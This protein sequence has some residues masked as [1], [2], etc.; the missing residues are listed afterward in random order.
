[1]DVVQPLIALIDEEGRRRQVSA[2][3]AYRLTE[4]Q[5]RA[6]LDLRLH[7]LTGLERD[8]IHDELN[9]IGVEIANY[10]EILRSRTRLYKIMRDELVEICCAR[11]IARLRNEYATPRRT[12]IEE[13]EFETDIED[14]IQREDMVV[15]VTNAGWIK[16]VPLSTYRA[17]RRGGKG[18]AGMAT[19]EEDFVRALY[20][21]NTHTPVLFFS[22]TGMVYKLKVYRLPL[23]HA[24][25]RAARRWSTYCPTSKPAE[26]S[27]RSCRCRRTKPPGA[28][29][30]GGF[31]HRLRQCPAQR[32][33]SD[34]TNVMRNGK[35]A[36]KLEGADAGDR[37]IGVAK[38][39]DARPTTFCWRRATAKA[40][41][42]LPPTMC[43]SSPAVRLSACVE[44]SW[45][46]GDAVISMSIPRH[47]DVS[48]GQRYAFL[49]MDAER[50]RGE[51][52]E[53]E[54]EEGD[55][56][57]AAAQL[58]EEQYADLAA[59][60]DCVGP[61]REGLRQAQLGL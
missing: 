53:V 25:E 55:A 40:F 7:R 12:S 46:T 44:S 58:S 37:L 15:T 48:T 23:E 20:I 41:A 33:L 47:E 57:T 24:A 11:R 52:E 59:R 60:Q 13:L 29:S 2:D 6:I 26:P 34:F 18:R 31:R 43:A 54:S 1:M 27:P 49:R 3:G 38:P 5:A 36:M 61:D 22:T 21:V 9:E 8:K 32:D 51:V 35:I 10:L 14:L 56:E 4:A 39:C 45:R 16:R 19:K 28:R 30:H 17:Q 50:R 42:S